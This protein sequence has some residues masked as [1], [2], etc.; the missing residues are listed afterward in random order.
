[1]EQWADKLD[2][3]LSFNERNVLTHAGKL[4]MD[5]AQKL[6]ADRYDDFDAKRK[7]FDAI[8]ADAEDIETLENLAKDLEGKT[9]GGE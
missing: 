5:V 9:G 7:E 2:S 6:A 4:R 1:M 3:F 8:A